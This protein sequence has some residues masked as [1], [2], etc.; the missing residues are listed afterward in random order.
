MTQIQFQSGFD[1]PWVNSYNFSTFENWKSW[2]IL[3][4]RQNYQLELIWSFGSS[5]NPRGKIFKVTTNGRKKEETNFVF[6]LFCHFFFAWTRKANFAWT[7]KAIFACCFYSRRQA[8][9]GKIA[10]T[11]CFSVAIF[12]WLVTTQLKNFF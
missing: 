3:G 8:R 10:N 11:K 1:S 6:L 5:S 9:N 7:K 2:S 4:N 12:G